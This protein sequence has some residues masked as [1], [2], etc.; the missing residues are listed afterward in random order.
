[1]ESISKVTRLHLYTRYKE[2]PRLHF[3]CV[4]AS[5]SVDFIS[6]TNRRLWPCKWY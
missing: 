3:T 5:S 2:L 4:V 6:T 1:M